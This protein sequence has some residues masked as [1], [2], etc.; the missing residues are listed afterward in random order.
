MKQSF[1]NEFS[2]VRHELM[3]AT[4]KGQKEDFHQNG[5]KALE[6]LR[7]MGE[8]GRRVKVFNFIKCRRNTGSDEYRRRKL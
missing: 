2:L 4:V 5:Q 3:E 1:Q 8:A 7:P 6:N